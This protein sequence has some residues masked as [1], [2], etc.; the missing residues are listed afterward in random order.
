MLKELCLENG[1][2]YI[3]NSN[4]SRENLQSDQVH[5]NEEGSCTLMN[6]LLHQMNN[7]F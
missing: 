5:L 1:D 7:V 4:I 3:D 6:N 2:F